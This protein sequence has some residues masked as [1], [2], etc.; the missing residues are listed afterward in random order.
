MGVHNAT[1][2]VRATSEER[3]TVVR[4]STSPL[5]A[6]AVG[7]VLCALPATA[8]AQGQLTETFHFA[9][10]D[11]LETQSSLFNGIASAPADL[12]PDDQRLF[13]PQTLDAADNDA[14]EGGNDNYTVPP[15]GTLRETFAFDVAPD[16]ENGSF[17]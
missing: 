15:V 2:S 13:W 4:R 1:K 12:Q 5:V 14:A 10:D 8:Q 9:H 7:L 6:I 11:T 16:E 17:R 3:G